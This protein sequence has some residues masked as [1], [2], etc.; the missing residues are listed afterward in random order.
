VQGSLKHIIECRVN[1]ALN[2]GQLP[3]IITYLARAAQLATARQVAQ[4]GSKNI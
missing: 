2:C 1:H 4:H 3:F